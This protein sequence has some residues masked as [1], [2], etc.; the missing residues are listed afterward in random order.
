MRVKKI[1]RYLGSDLVAS[2]NEI[3]EKRKNTST[4]VKHKKAAC[5]YFPYFTCF[6]INYH[7]SI[8]NTMHLKYL[9]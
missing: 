9:K 3:I 8:D 6:F 5:K 1:N 2:C 4:N 7:V